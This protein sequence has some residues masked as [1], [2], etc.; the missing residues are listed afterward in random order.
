MAELKVAIIGGSGVYQQKFLEEEQNLEVK[1]P[2]G[3]VTIKEGLYKGRRVFF[4]ARHGGSHT[5]PPHKVNYRANIA[6]LK[7]LKA[8]A[9]IATAAVGTLNKE[10]PPGSRVIIDQFIDF[11]RQRPLTFF[12]DEKRLVV[13][14]DFSEPYCQE[15]RKTILKAGNKLG[16]KMIDGGC[17][18]C[19][20]GP[21]FE[22][23]AEIKMFKKWGADLVGM[24]NLPEAV[25]ARE[26]GLCYATI[27]LPTNYAAGISA[28]PLSY[29]E[30]IEVMDKDKP[31]LDKL[32]AK[33]VKEINPAYSCSCRE[34]GI[35]FP[36]E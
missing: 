1:T 31:E 11:T 32:L 28:K 30:V 18:L 2:Y 27:A 25:L 4:M 22:A 26:A 3:S 35:Y 17:Y 34:A 29:A 16:Q 24:T 33:C 23:P 7:K 5:V 21:R 15:I 14:T 12:E 10:M 19:T 13:H 9:V 8:D 36:E 6:A 20:E